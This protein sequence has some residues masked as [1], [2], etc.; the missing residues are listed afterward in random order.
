MLRYYP[1][2]KYETD[3]SGRIEED[4]DMRYVPNAEQKVSEWSGGTTTELYLYPPDGS[5]RERRFKVRLSTAVCRDETS[6]FTKL[7]DTKRI[8]MV[9]E[10]RKSVV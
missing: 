5:Y 9:L 2:R 8:L 4:Y 1:G 3:H 10:D 7:S 6:V